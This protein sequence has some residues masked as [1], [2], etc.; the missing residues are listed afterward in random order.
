M[1]NCSPEEGTSILRVEKQSG[2]ENPALHHF[3]E[4]GKTVG[5]ISWHSWARWDRG[6]YW[7]TNGVVGLLGFSGWLG[8]HDSRLPFIPV[9]L[10]ELL[11][12]LVPSYFVAP[13]SAWASHQNFL[14][15]VPSSS[16][17][18]VASKGSMKIR[19]SVSVTCGAVSLHAGGARGGGQRNRGQ[20]GTKATYRHEGNKRYS[21]PPAWKAL[22]PLAI[23]AEIPSFSQQAAPS[24]CSGKTEL[25]DD[26]FN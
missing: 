5:D 18:L 10:G 13:V 25:I 20:L 4:P 26:T 19:R 3:R 23:W 12:M 14:S 6:G 24:A 2:D 11:M 8:S 16:L 9:T 7:W 21:L 17:S 22:L 15:R 1:E